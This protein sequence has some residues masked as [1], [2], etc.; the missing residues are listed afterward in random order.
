MQD[1]ETSTPDAPTATAS[2]SQLQ[3]PIVPTEKSEQETE[4]GSLGEQ[5]SILRFKIF[6]FKN[7]SFNSL[8]SLLASRYD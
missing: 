3:P 6:T 5:V 1:E 4:V 2:P 8:G 7:K